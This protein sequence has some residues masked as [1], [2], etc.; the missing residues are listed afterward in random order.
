MYFLQQL[1]EQEIKETFFIE[2]LKT[3]SESGFL[4]S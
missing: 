4:I 2:F 3:G 1:G